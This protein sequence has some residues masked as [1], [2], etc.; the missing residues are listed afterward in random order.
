MSNKTKLM[1]VPKAFY[2]TIE[3]IS[4]KEGVS[5]T[6]FLRNDGTRIIKNADALTD[7]F[8]ML[9]KKKR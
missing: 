6:R 8:G 3:V 1:R 2:E 7:I 5:M 4:K 9:R